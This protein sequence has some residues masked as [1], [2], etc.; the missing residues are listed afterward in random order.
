MNS[1]LQFG[2]SNFT[3][4]SIAADD[5][6]SCRNGALLNVTGGL[7]QTHLTLDFKSVEVGLGIDY[8]VVIFGTSTNGANHFLRGYYFFTNFL[9]YS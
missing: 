9:L 7:E 8:S 6:S 1:T 5:R 2:P 3:I 4:R